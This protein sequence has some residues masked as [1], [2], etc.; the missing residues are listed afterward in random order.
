MSKT[1]ARVLL[2]AVFGF[3]FAFLMALGI[4]LLQPDITGLLLI[5][6]FIG[7]VVYIAVKLVV[8]VAKDTGN[9][10]QEQ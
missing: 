2:V 9:W 4:I 7:I 1:K 3:P 6:Y 8:S 10:D 5:D